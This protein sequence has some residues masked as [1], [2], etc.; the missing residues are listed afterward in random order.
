MDLTNL[1]E[2]LVSGREIVITLGSTISKFIPQFSAENIAAFL[3]LVLCFL[4]VN[5]LLN[6]ISGKYS[7]FL[8]KILAT[9]GLFYL[10]W[11]W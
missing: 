7:N 6:M 3:V 8:T 1:K 2:I 4:I 10:L 9:G 5:S 11:L